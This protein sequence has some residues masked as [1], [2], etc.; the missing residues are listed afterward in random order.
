M[1]TVRIVSVLL[2]A[3]RPVAWLGVCK[4]GCVTELRA[5]LLDIDGTLVDSNDAH[6]DSWRVALDHFG[7]R[8]AFERVR[9]LIGKGGDKLLAE[10]TGIDVESAIGAEIE[11]FRGKL[12][13]RD[14]LPKIRPFPSVRELLMRLRADGLRLVVATSA[15]SSDMDALLEISGARDLVHE[16]TSSDDASNSK[17]DP[18]IIRAALK[19]AGALPSEC[20]M[21]GDTPYDVEAASRAG[22]ST[23]ALRCGGWQAADLGGAVAI[24]ADPA[25]LLSRYDTSSFATRD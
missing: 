8:V 23:V 25:D 11:K 1:S 7:H 15:K 3:S 6:A 21:L 10:L 16:R 24:Y 14:Y 20:L 13:T 17:P 22:V 9:A 12:F 18:D 19:K 4:V 5:V 2:G